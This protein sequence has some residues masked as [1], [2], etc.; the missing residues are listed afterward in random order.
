[1][2]PISILSSFLSEADK[3]MYENATVGSSIVWDDFLG[4]D[5][6][7]ISYELLDDKKVS[8]SLKE[9]LLLA[10][11]T[12]EIASNSL[13]KMKSKSFENCDIELKLLDV[14]EIREIRP[15]YIKDYVADV[16]KIIAEN[17]SNTES[18]KNAIGRLIGKKTPVFDIDSYK[19]KI[20]RT[21]IPYAAD[22]KYLL[23]RPATY[24]TKSSNDVLMFL[25]D[26]IN[27]KA[28]SKGEFTSTYDE[29]K[30]V[31]KESDKKMINLVDTIIK[32]PVN[33]GVKSRVAYI[34]TTGYTELVK[35]VTAMMIRNMTN[36]ISTVREISNTL[37][38]VQ[39]EENTSPYDESVTVLDPVE[40][41]QMRVNELVE[42]A[43]RMITH[44]AFA[45]VEMDENMDTNAWIT[46]I[47]A[48]RVFSNVLNKLLDDFTSPGDD[49]PKD[50]CVKYNLTNRK[51]LECI[52]GEALR[53]RF[54]LSDHGDFYKLA[55]RD[56]T[57]LVQ[58]APEFM[59]NFRTVILGSL[60]K[61]MGFIEINPNN[62]MDE[63]FVKNAKELIVHL[64]EQLVKEVTLLYPIY[65]KG[66][67]KTINDVLNEKSGEVVSDDTPNYFDDLYQMNYEFTQEAAEDRFNA[68]NSMYQKEWEKELVGSFYEDENNNGNNNQ[69]NNQQ[70]N[71]GNN[72]GGNNNNTNNQPNNNNNSGNNNSGNNNGNNGNQQNNNSNG[73]QNGNQNNNNQNNQNNNQQNGNNNDNKNDDKISF[74]EKLTGILQKV[75]DSINNFTQGKGKKNKEAVDRHRN[76]LM[77]RSY[78]NISVQVT[79]YIK[80]NYA[81]LIQTSLDASLNINDN[82]LKTMTKDQ[83]ADAILSSASI[84][85]TGGSDGDVTN[86]LMEKL[87]NAIA[88]GAG[89]KVAKTY[90]NSAVKPIV[91]DMIGFVE[92]Y[93]QGDQGGL[94]S[95]LKKLT[96]DKLS[97]LDE[98]A[99]KANPNDKNDHTSENISFIKTLLTTEISAVGSVCRERFNEYMTKVLPE[100][101]KGDPAGK[102]DNSN[103]NN[104]GND[105]N[106][107]NNGDQQ[108]NQD[109]GAV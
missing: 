75:I 20:V 53:D 3:V 38:V 65:L 68:V 30:L 17:A 24:I 93:L 89:Q 97:Q 70:N 107:N 100:C 43:E 18:L 55:K 91:N 106:Q 103:N 15:Y 86:N 85:I 40:T 102:V 44:P 45:D 37:S 108:N 69:G 92:N 39:I 8:S 33:H 35:Y 16:T 29:I 22:S 104:Q 77:N 19:Q 48:C 11:S 87:T 58:Y 26:Y 72:N 98:K 94:T 13:Q 42:I 82:N 56:L 27:L 52:H 54:V 83:I 10:Q 36:Y 61:A 63:C 5:P 2:E 71:N 14:G 9:A 101:W 62:V 25:S 50:I 46:P 76:F 21:S 74:S 95:T 99:K 60:K 81:N 105:N 4:K 12:I 34:I 96:F 49:S 80:R 78:S 88:V 79:P 73:N 59:T 64:E 23:S 66:R 1:M 57:A 28:S 67:I 7:A 84:K 6:A 41:M 51:F 32:L 90:Q 109:Q 31:K 47:K